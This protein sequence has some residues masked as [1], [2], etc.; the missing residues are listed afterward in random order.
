MVSKRE[1]STVEVVHFHLI[2]LMERNPGVDQGLRKL[3]RVQLSALVKGLACCVI[4]RERTRDFCHV[5]VVLGVL[6]EALNTDGMNFATILS[7]IAQF[8]EY[9]RRANLRQ[10]LQKEKGC[11]KDAHDGELLGLWIEDYLDVTDWMLGLS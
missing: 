2:N 10:M 7:E 5:N 6:V 3:N 9:E 8:A 1:L 11:K 4:D